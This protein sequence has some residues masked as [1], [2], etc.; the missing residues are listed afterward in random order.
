MIFESIFD[1]YYI[2]NEIEHVSSYF[3]LRKLICTIYIKQF[4]GFKNVIINYDIVD[5]KGISV[6]LYFILLSLY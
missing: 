1:I 3:V 2:L 4:K 6:F 5:I